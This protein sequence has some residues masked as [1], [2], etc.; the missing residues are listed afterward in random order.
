M[1]TNRAIVHKGF[2]EAGIIGVGE[3]AEAAEFEEGLDMLQ[4]LYSSF[5]GNELGE[6][7]ASVNYGTEGLIN[8]YAID[9]DIST[10]T[11]SAFLFVNKR[12][13]LNLSATQT[14][15]LHPNPADGARLGVIDNAGNLATNSLILNGNG[16]HI[17]SA[18]SVTLATN[19]LN[20]EWFYRADIGGWVRVTDIDPDEVSPL[21]REFDDLL[22]TA[23]AIRLNPRYGAETAQETQGMLSRM[24]RLFRARYKQV[25]EQKSEL[26]LTRLPNDKF[27]YSWRDR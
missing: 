23:L 9:E 20:R 8:P 7:L 1:S 25:T 18:N 4:G 13:I 3:L 6:P 11:Q 14:L 10:N 12:Y 2:R 26:G 19:L 17:E 22:T 15:Y 27:K 21:P 5:F 24:K 16:R